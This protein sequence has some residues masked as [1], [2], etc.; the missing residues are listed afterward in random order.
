MSLPPSLHVL[1]SG[2]IGLL[3][4]ARIR[5]ALPSFPLTVLLRERN[6]WRLGGAGTI[7]AVV[8]PGPWAVAEDPPAAASIPIAIS[9]STAEYSSAAA[10]IV[11]L[12][13]EV[14]AVGGASPPPPERQIRNLLLATKAPDAAE[15]LRSVAG[16]LH[17]GGCR[18]LILGNGALA[19]RDEL[20]GV[21]A[22]VGRCFR[23]ARN[24]DGDG[25]GDGDGGDGA[26]IVSLHL[27]STTHG[28]HH[29]KGDRADGGD[30]DAVSPAYS[31]V[32]AGLGRTYVGAGPFAALF[33]R[34]GLLRSSPATEA[35]M[36]VLQWKKLATNCA[37]NPFTAL[38]LC[39]NGDLLAAGR[40]MASA[41]D[42]VVKE[43]ASVATEEARAA[44]DVPEEALAELGYAPLRAFVDEVVRATAENTSS[45]LQD[46]QA[47]RHPT[48]VRWLNGYV[49][50]VGRERHGLACPVNDDLCTRIEELSKGFGENTTNNRR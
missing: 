30:G 11:D 27:A 24:A 31:I 32:H 44:G 48:E 10:G 22:S 20:E 42:E 36:R 38:R 40:G 47:R 1:G 13:A 34:A 19:V 26:G 49:A 12:P 5:G 25:D 33:D 35:E 39:R 21:L 37:V 18:V 8:A 46:V 29:G 14:I 4:A 17:S 28:A 41:M 6:R 50:R 43:V 7:A 15:A 2:P 3:Y 16:R 23:R 9:V 45:M